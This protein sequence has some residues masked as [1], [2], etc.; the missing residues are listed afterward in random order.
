MSGAKQ[1]LCGPVGGDTMIVRSVVFV[2]TTV[3]AITVNMYIKKSG[4]VSKYVMAKNYSLPAGERLYMDAVM[5]L[6]SG[7]ELEAEASAAASIDCNV[8]G[9]LKTP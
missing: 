6:G 3:G 8:F 7:D 4:G 9:V 5:T 2:N 1:T